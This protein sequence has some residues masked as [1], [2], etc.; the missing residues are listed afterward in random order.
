M[1]E[2]KKREMKFNALNGKIITKKK[3]PKKQVECLPSNAT[4]IRGNPVNILGEFV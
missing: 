4:F 1:G 2:I 3:L